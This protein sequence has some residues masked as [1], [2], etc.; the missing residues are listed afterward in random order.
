MQTVDDYKMLDVRQIFTVDP[1]VKRDTLI[2]LEKLGYSG[3]R[4]HFDITRLVD[5]FK[6]EMAGR[7]VVVEPE[8]LEAQGTAHK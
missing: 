6:R 7:R 5:R 4:L 3:E 2:A 1:T 8:D